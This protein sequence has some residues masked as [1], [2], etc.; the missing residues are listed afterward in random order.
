M[1]H[2]LE[3]LETHIGKDKVEKLKSANDLNIP[4]KIIDKYQFKTRL[5]KTGNIELTSDIAIFNGHIGVRF[6][7]YIVTTNKKFCLRR[8]YAVDAT[9][10]SN[11][12]ANMGEFNNAADMCDFF[13]KWVEN[14]LTV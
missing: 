4:Q 11:P 9:N 6:V 2:L 1:R 14:K 13:I 5:L 10:W 3:F 7:F 12:A 8:Q